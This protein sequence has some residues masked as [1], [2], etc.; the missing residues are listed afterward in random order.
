MFS[1][2]LHLLLF[3]PLTF[4]PTGTTRIYEGVRNHTSVYTKQ[5]LKEDE[6]QDEGVYAE[7]RM[8]V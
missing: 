5:E 8:Q 6:G 2:Y 4:D 7:Q 1:P 3:S